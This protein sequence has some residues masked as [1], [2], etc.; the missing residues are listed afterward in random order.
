L[1][2]ASDQHSISYFGISLSYDFTKDILINK[3]EI[4]TEFRS[5]GLMFKN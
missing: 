4:R 5:P 2:D 1:R 3:K